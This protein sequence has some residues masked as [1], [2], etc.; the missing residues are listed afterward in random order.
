MLRCI[1]LLTGAA[2]GQGAFLL[3]SIYYLT[4][5]PHKI[6]KIG[7]G[8]GLASLAILI[9]DWGGSVTQRQIVEGHC[10]KAI[11]VS[12]VKTRVAPLGLI[13]VSLGAVLTWGDATAVVPQFL[14]GAALGIALSIFNITGLLDV[15]DVRATHGYFQGFPAL[16]L[17]LCLLLAPDASPLVYGYA[18]SLGCV[19]M[20]AQQLLFVRG[21]GRK[22][23]ECPL[24]PAPS[25]PMLRSEGAKV[26]VA[27]LPGQL[28]TRMVPSVMV[29]ASVAELAAV[30]NTLK[31]AQG[32]LNQVVTLL[33]RAEYT[34]LQALLRSSPKRLCILRS[35]Y[36]SI[37]GGLLV[38]SAGMLA[39]WATAHATEISGSVIVAA[40][41]Q[42]MLWLATSSI[43]HVKQ[44][45]GNNGDQARYGIAI[46]ALFVVL[47]LCLPSLSVELVIATEMMASLVALSLVFYM[48]RRAE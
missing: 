10:P 31:Q 30:Y 39:L 34:A 24:R 28:I 7:T 46:I 8:Y 4:T 16:G 37:G 32:L 25:V 45:R 19:V 1:S 27:S 22:E 20:F 42:S 13:A 41:F 38:G 44:V 33:R 29:L 2:L 18:F 9:I 5:D 17:S 36:V 15:L 26:L 48:R 11:L 3:T 23:R 47:F 35:Q 14:Q 40:Y 12:Y 21:V 6:G 43:F